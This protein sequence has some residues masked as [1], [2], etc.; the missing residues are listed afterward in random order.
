[1]LQLD[2]ALDVEIAAVA[3]ALADDSG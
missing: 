1:M 2:G 3:R